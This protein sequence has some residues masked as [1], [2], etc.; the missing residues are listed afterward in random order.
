MCQNKDTFGK[1]TIFMLLFFRLFFKGCQGL[2]LMVWSEFLPQN[3]VR[4]ARLVLSP[5]SLQS[6]TSQLKSYSIFCH[7]VP[8]NFSDTPKCA[9]H[10]SFLPPNSPFS[11]ILE[12]PSPCRPECLEASW[13][14]SKISAYFLPSDHFLLLQHAFCPF[15]NFILLYPSQTHSYWPHWCWSL[16]SPQLLCLDKPK[17]QFVLS[18][19]ARP[20]DTFLTWISKVLKTTI[21]DRTEEGKAAEGDCLENPHPALLAQNTNCC[22]VF[23][24]SELIHYLPISYINTYSL[25]T[26]KVVKWIFQTADVLQ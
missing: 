10:K 5:P 23:T 17:M 25:D 8:W 3:Q 15:F 9:L 18:T 14:Q 2:L 22:F 20:Q 4:H 24:I 21:L 7:W 19:K 1:A 13:S 26:N 16:P 6:L 11:L 12:L